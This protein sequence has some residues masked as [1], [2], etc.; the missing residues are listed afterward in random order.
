MNL[1]YKMKY[2]TNIRKKNAKRPQ[3][4]NAVSYRQDISLNRLPLHEEKM[5][6]IDIHRCL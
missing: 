1:L 4:L 3:I 5:S 2:L 6:P